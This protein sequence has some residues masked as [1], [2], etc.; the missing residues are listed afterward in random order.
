MY[1][2]YSY[3]ELLYYCGKEGVYVRR[4]EEASEWLIDIVNFQVLLNA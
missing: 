3:N 2:V 4:R 1:Y